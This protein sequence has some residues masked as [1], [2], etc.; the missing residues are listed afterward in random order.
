[1]YST[2]PIV[3]SYYVYNTK[4]TRVAI[5]IKNIGK[6]N[7]ASLVWASFID[8]F[9]TLYVHFG[10]CQKCSNLISTETKYY[11]QLQ[12]FKATCGRY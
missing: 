1:M 12:Y 10:T 9:P 11:K 7:I 6:D 3:W 2:D 5:T 4:T 8:V